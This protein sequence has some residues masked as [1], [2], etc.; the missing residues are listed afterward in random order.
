MARARKV[1][2]QI[3]GGSTNLGRLGQKGTTGAARTGSSKKRL[4]SV[5]MTNR[6]VSQ[7]SR[8]ISANLRK[9]A[10]GPGTA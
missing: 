9:G 8:D 10:M 2:T 7:R 4:G 6:N 3:S 1:G 5:A